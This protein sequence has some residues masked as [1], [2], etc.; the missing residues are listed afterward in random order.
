MNKEM[1]HR[2]KTAGEYQ[3]KAVRALFSKEVIGHLDVIEK[4]VKAMV[5]EVLA[6]MV[7]DCDKNNKCEETQSH[8]KS[9]EIKKVDIV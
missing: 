8:E 9:S 4:E 5:L 6:E 7:K 3:Q 1:L 2:M